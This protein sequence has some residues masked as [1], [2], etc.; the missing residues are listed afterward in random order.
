MLRSS[1]SLQGEKPQ[2]LSLLLV[3]HHSLGI[4]TTF[5]TSWIT[6]SRHLDSVQSETNRLLLLK[7]EILHCDNLLVVNS[8]SLAGG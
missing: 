8:A 3:L 1:P 6:S 7:G 2:V 5:P 4:E